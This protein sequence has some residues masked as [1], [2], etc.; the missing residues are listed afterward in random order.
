LDMT[1]PAKAENESPRRPYGG[2]VL[3]AFGVIFLPFAGRRRKKIAHLTRRLAVLL[4]LCVALAM[5]IGGCGAN[6][7]EQNFSFTVS[8]A[9]GSL[10]HS[11]TAQLKVN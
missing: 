4:A 6:L 8:A 5:G 2:A 1:L 10:S 3:V 9:S 7:S 11:V